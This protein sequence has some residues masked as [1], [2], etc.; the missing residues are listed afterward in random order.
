MSS[1]RQHPLTLPPT[2]FSLLDGPVINA[3]SW[4]R[5]ATA[6]CSA[7][8]WLFGLQRKSV[9]QRSLQ[10]GIPMPTGVKATT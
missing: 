8:A 9:T 2:L 1:E 7:C 6:S 3:A 10:R 4:V 5:H